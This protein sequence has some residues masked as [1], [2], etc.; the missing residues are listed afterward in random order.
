VALGKHF[1]Q[2]RQ[3]GGIG[4]VKQ[5]R[6]NKE[7][8]QRPIFEQRRD[9]RD[10]GRFVTVV[11]SARHVVIDVTRPDAGERPQGGNREGHD[12]EENAAIGEKIA[13]E[14]HRYRGDHIARGIKGL[15][16][17]LAPIKEVST[18]HAY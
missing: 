1:A 3:H 6:A 2:E 10:A 11:G 18:H 13:D 5:H 12:K 4:E 16:P 17:A 14:T 8:Q 9:V 15:V 7:D